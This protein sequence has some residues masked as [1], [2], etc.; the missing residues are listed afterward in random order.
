MDLTDRFKKIKLL[1]LDVDGVLT[2]GRLYFGP[3]GEE[4][5]VFHVRDGYG[6]KLWHD[7]GFRS[8]IISG[9]DSDLVS[10]RASQLGMHFVYQGNDDKLEA[11]AEI[12]AE[13]GVSSD[14]I[15]FV[16]DDSLDLP[17]FE[18]V[19]LAVAVADAHESAKQS[20]HYVT[21]IDGGRGAVRE[22]VDILLRAKAS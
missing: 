15:A 20:A 6:I 22:V 10:R 16:G 9:R 13:A 18:K 21:T 14:E 17:V 19:G 1:L 2:D 7:A 5:K 4:L 11:L 3:A 12:A 8:G